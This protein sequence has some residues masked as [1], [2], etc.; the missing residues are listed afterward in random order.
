MSNSST[1]SLTRYS[2]LVGA[3]FSAATASAVPPPGN[4]VFSSPYATGVLNTSATSLA[5]NAVTGAW[6]WDLVQSQG[7]SSIK[8]N[9]STSLTLF[10]QNIDTVGATA[11]VEFRTTI[12]SGFESIS[13]DYTS[14]SFVNSST[15][16]LKNG[17][18]TTLGS[19]GTFSH[20]FAPGDT[21]GFRVSATYNSSINS[22]TLTIS[23][24]TATAAVPEPASAG[25]WIGLGA[26][27]LIA[28]R[29]LRRRRDTSAPTQS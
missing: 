16:W 22:A 12:V 24:L 26:A 2:A 14:V 28:M 20:L 11:S 8:S 9:S 1:T 3:T 21:F 15:G 23:N 7:T 29:E 18:Q 5:D 6:T 17:T 19:S 27:G 4:I 10:S 13:F 25:T